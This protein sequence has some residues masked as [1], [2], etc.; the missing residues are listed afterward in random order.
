[1]VT[2]RL[3]YVNASHTLTILWYY[4]ILGFNS[5]LKFSII[6]LGKMGHFKIFFMNAL[7]VANAYLTS[8]STFPNFLTGK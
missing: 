4:F 2:I 8:Y 7:S 3:L 5:N 6:Y 1:M